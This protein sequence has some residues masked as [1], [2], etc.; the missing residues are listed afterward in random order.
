MVVRSFRFILQFN[1]N[2]TITTKL[3]H[4]LKVR[5]NAASVQLFIS[6]KV[7]QSYVVKKLQLVFKSF[8]IVWLFYVLCLSITATQLVGWQTRDFVLMQNFVQLTT[9][10]S[11]RRVIN[12]SFQLIN[13]LIY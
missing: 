9:Y 5:R 11:V 1:K 4:Q 10:E 8:Y 2:Y 12:K 6:F 7:F 3:K 13:V